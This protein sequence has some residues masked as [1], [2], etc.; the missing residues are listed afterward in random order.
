[1]EAT[2]A[3]EEGGTSQARHFL[4]LLLA[5]GAVAMSY[6]VTLPWLPVL[7]GR[8]EGARIAEHTGWLTGAYTLAVLVCSPLWGALSDR[9]DRRWVMAAGLSGAT[10]SLA[11]LE[12]AA[13]LEMLYAS[14]VLAGTASAAVLPAVLSAVTRATARERRQ[15]RFAWISSAT[16]AGFLLGPVVS[17]AVEGA[18]GPSGVAWV[19]VLCGIAGL[20]AFTLP[21]PSALQASGAADR[22]LSPVPGTGMWH[23]LLLTALTVFGIT[24]AEVG[25][26]LLLREVAFYFAVCSAVMIFVQLAAY[27]WLERSFGEH[28]LVTGAFAAMAIGL[29]LLAWRASWTPAAAFVLA[30][31]AIGIL[32]PALTVRV[33]VA[34]A[35]NQGAAMG[36][37]AGAASLGQAIG[38]ALTGTLFAAGSGL[39]FLVAAL[40][41]ATGGV[42]AAKGRERDL[43]RV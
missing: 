37:Q 2:P 8:I 10:L 12:A 19:A 38:A 41:L 21:R 3:G 31:A 16:A 40:L 30:A 34:A 33:S 15:R 17:S 24:V 1:M 23:A 32:L 18:P 5:A 35:A 4:V 25:V 36:R 9:L 14:R 28:R 7:L 13:S 43:L 11:A 39:P 22:N 42:L 29:S 20:L 27:P 26:T 6:G